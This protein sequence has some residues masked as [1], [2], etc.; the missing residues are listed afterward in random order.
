[1]T[2]LRLSAGSN[3]HEL[4]KQ[5]GELAERQLPFATAA[6]LTDTAQAGRDKLRDTLDQHF[7]VRARR[8]LERGIT[9]QRAEKRDWPRPFAVI[10]TR[11][12]FMALHVT[13]GV[14]RPQRGAS[15]LAIPAK[16]IKRT[17]TG[18]IPKRWKP[19]QVR[20]RKSAFVT[21]DAIKHRPGKRARVQLQTVHLLRKRARIEPTWPFVAIVEREARTVFPKR[22]VRRLRLA[23]ITAKN[24]HPS[25]RR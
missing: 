7:R 20:D 6:A 9:I 15:R 3:A 5:F 24:R 14:K 8:R 19:R 17:T 22:M 23:V 4:A 1:M 2:N 18:R 12:E 10:G 16:W 25:R 11:D 21:D 13:G